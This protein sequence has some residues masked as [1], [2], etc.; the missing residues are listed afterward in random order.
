MKA[1]LQWGYFHCLG[2]GHFVIVLLSLTAPRKWTRWNNCITLRFYL[3]LHITAKLDL[4]RWLQQEDFNK[5]TAV[6]EILLRLKIYEGEEENCVIRNFKAGA[7][8]WI[9]LR[10]LN[11]E[12]RKGPLTYSAWDKEYTQL[13]VCTHVSHVPCLRSDCHQ[14]T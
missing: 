1:V 3:L 4:S 5:K 10:Y 6:I 11:Q 9:M 2:S 12:G 13:R 14:I 7:F 8:H